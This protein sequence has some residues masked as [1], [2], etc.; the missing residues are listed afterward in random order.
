MGV[1]GSSATP[2]PIKWGQ[3]QPITQTILDIVKV[4]NLFEPGSIRRIEPGEIEPGLIK[5]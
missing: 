3:S 1:W 4:S 2:G 5:F